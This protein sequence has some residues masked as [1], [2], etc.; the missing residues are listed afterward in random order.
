MLIRRHI[1][2]RNLERFIDREIGLHHLI[3]MS[4]SGK[5]EKNSVGRFI[6]IEITIQIPST[7]IDEEE[8]I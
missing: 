6:P 7:P 4:V 5:E 8:V 3:A 2:Q 1:S